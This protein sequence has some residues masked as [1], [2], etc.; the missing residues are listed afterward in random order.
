MHRG[1]FAPSPTGQLHLGSAAAALFCAAAARRSGGKLVLRI[2]DIDIPRVLDGAEI[3]IERDLAWLGIVFDESPASGGPA[4]PYRQSE[5]LGLYEEALSVLVRAGHVYLCDCSRAEVARVASAPH[6]GEEGLLYPGTC[7]DRGMVDRAFKRPPAYRLRAPSG[8]IGY[9]DRAEGSVVV[10]TRIVG[11]FVLRR[12]DGVFSYQFATLVDDLT[13]DVTEVVR[14]RDLVSSAPRQALLANLLDREPPMYAHVPL[15]TG[16]DG[17]RLAKRDGAVTIAGQ[18]ERGT[19]PRNLVRAIAEAYGHKLTSPTEP[20][21]ELAKKFDA[22]SF[23]GESVD[24][25]HV[26]DFL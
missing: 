22:K 9:F 17:S 26:I 16:P 13:M 14:G 15:L 8:T 1:R 5:R 11:D 24:V 23:P 21:A 25:R 20:L 2:E 4:A 12:G 3:S 18:R 6:L 19:D 7:R 10:D